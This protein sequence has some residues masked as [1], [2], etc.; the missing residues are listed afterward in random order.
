MTVE[1]TRPGKHMLTITTPVM[2][3]AGIFGYGDV[4]RDLI[5][6]DKLGAI[7][8]N[9]VTYE[10][11]SPATG[12]R[13]VPLSAGVLVHT[14]LPNT[15][16]SK[17]LGRFRNLWSMLPVPVILHLVGTTPDQVRK[18]VQRLDEEEAIAAVELGLA[19]D[20][21][22]RDAVELVR[23][24]VEH[25]EKP[26]LV[27]LPFGDAPLLADYVAD[28][29]AGALVLAAPPRG[30]ARDPLTGRLVSGRLYGPLVKPQVLRL[31]GQLIRRVG[32]VPV[33]GV[34]GIHS[35]QDARDYL[36]AGARAVQVDTAIWSSPKLL[37]VIARDLGGLVLTRES[38]ALDDEWHPGIGKTEKEQTQKDRKRGAPSNGG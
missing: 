33:I 5:N 8:T 16:L 37:E 15:G 24:A 30:T 29:G 26:L 3:A 31:V 13:I 4:Y 23:A 10:P 38:G 1:L 27:R 7:V 2:P 12:T 20:I 6:F 36:E 35:T 21:N 32:E 25:F 14:G 11:W 18:A 9:P 22:R 34:G 17:T 28:A 19:D